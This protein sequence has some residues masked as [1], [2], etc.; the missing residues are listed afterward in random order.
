MLLQRLVIRLFNDT[1]LT[2]QLV[3]WGTVM[4]GE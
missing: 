1:H 4:S 3:D 2:A